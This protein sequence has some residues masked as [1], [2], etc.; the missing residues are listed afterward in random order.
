MFWAMSVGG[1]FP[2][3]GTLH[4]YSA[5]VLV[6]QD[7]AAWVGTFGNPNDVAFSLSVLVPIAFAAADRR[8]LVLRLL[9]FS[10]I[11]TYL[12]AIWV[13]YSRGGMLGLLA[14]VLVMGLRYRGLA[15][16]L[17]ASAILAATLVFV[18]YYWTRDEGFSHLSDDDT[19]YSR[20]TTMKAGLAMFADHPLLG[21]GFNCSEVAW[22]LYVTN[23]RG[24]WLHNHNTY[25][26]ALAETGILGAAP[27]FLLIAF[28]LVGLRSARRTRSPAGRSAAALEASLCGFLVCG[29]ANGLLLSWFPF[30]L[31]GLSTALRRITAEN[32]AAY[33]AGH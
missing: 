13:T 33:P 27:Y 15:G 7:R 32:R 25:T 1:L 14:V 12:A 9:S 26:Q 16:R 23:V 17:M 3:I 2:A 8:G 10:I 30:L 22:P 31:L 24:P 6:E 21:V 28:G 20:I 18:A 11:A 5:G 4:S 19:F 29:L